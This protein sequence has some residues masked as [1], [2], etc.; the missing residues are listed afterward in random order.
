MNFKLNAFIRLPTRSNNIPSN[1]GIES[2]RKT[3]TATTSTHKN[4]NDDVDVDVASM[5]VLILLLL[6][7]ISDNKKGIRLESKRKIYNGNVCM[8]V[9]DEFKMLLTNGNKN[10]NHHTTF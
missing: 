10:N 8:C 5:S 1:N 7:C 9:F 4:E 2:N 3:T 6:Y